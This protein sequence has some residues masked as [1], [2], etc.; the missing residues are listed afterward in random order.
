MSKSYSVRI[1]LDCERYDF[2]L[3]RRIFDVLDKYSFESVADCVEFIDTS[4]KSDEFAAKY[5]GC[6]LKLEILGLDNEVKFFITIHIGWNR[7]TVFLF[8]S[9]ESVLPLK[10]EYYHKAQQNSIWGPAPKW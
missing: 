9:N 5:F 1:R 4:L 6:K 2:V 10:E 3:R 8:S 7:E